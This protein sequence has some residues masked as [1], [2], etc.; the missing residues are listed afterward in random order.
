MLNNLTLQGRLTADPELKT[1]GDGI[2]VLEFTLAS[3]R[4]Y[5]L[6]D[7]ER[8]TDFINVVAWR[9]TAEFIAKYFTKGRQI[10]VTGRIQVRQWRDQDGGKHRRTEV[11]ANAA[12][13]CDSKKQ[14]PEAGPFEELPN[15]PV[16]FN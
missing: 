10:L 3:D 7:G 2:P 13:F 14:D 8:P 6:A 9:G 5:T 11:L 4:D 15:E 1:V 16:P 12:Y